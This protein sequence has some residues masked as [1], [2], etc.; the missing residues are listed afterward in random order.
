MR[1]AKLLVI[2]LIVMLLQGCWGSRETDEIAYVL[3]MGFDKGPDNNIM[4]TFQIANPKAIAGPA[5]GGGGEKEKPLITIS[6]LAPLP[7]AAFN[8]INVERS[9][10]ISLLHT[11]AFIFS[12]EL[13]REGLIAYLNPLQR[14]PET[15]GTAFV[16]VS[17]GKAREFMVKNQ[18]ELEITPSKQY[19]LI[20]RIERIHALAPVVQFQDFY[21][22]TK[23]LDIQPVAPLVALQKEGFESYRPEGFGKLGDYTAGNLPSNKGETQFLG[24]AVFKM[25]R[26]VGQLTGDE[27]R[28]FNM[29]TGKMASS[30]ITVIDPLKEN[31]AIGLTLKQARKPDIKVTLAGGRPLIEI[32]VFQEPEIVGIASGINYEGEKLKPVLE[33]ELAN[34]IKER[35]QE[36]I[37]RTQ[38]EFA[39][40]IF[41]F[42]RYARAN[43]LTVSDWRDYD[44]QRAYPG[45]K[46]DVK[47]SLKIRRTGLM[48]ET[49]PVR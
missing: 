49:E 44:W 8:L 6:T 31:S 7:I 45:A 42:G 39:S 1:A 43:F 12:E 27:T 4:M 22:A 5:G 15:R 40:D 21:R 29:L 18:P 41:G 47:V 3:V 36:L 35:C 34:L 24:A 16:Y 9:R 10:E 13:A 33:K 37:A 25:D 30:F 17:K 46:V 26:M 19:E 11:T 20:S 23:A 28:Y 2:F 14:Y 38:E 32:E 48:L